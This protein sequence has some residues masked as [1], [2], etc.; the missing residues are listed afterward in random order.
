MSTVYL[1]N[2]Q[3][4]IH[5]DY[6]LEHMIRSDIYQLRC[7][8]ETDSSRNVQKIEYS[9][10]LKYYKIYNDFAIIVP[11]QKYDEWKGGSGEYKRLISVV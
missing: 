5:R 11:V 7:D 9:L 1:L 4:I 3:E 10:D 6:V 2:K 8:R